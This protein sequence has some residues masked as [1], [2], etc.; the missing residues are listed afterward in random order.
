MAEDVCYYEDLEYSVGSVIEFDGDEYVCVDLG[1]G[2]R[3][4]KQ[5]RSKPAPTDRPEPSI[6]AAEAPAGAVASAAAKPPRVC[7]YAGKKYSIGAPLKAS[8]GKTYVCDGSKG[9]N[10]QWVPQ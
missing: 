3:W 1:G 10:P 2:P 7:Y 4:S 8:N 6:S 5:S 9:G